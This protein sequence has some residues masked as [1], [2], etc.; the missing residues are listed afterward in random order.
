MKSVIR[1]YETPRAQ[2][3]RKGSL[4]RAFSRFFANVGVRRFRHYRRTASTSFSRTA[5]LDSTLGP[6]ERKRSIKRFLGSTRTHR[7][8]GDH[9]LRDIS[10]KYFIFKYPPTHPRTSRASRAS[11]GS[12]TRHFCFRASFFLKSFY[13]LPTTKKKNLTSSLRQSNSPA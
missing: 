1:F 8:R 10:D 13:T 11:R 3:R 7:F 5:R 2:S 4:P 9:H 12:S 6:R